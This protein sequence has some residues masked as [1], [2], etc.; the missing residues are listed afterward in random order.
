MTTSATPK[1]LVRSFISS[2]IWAWIVTSSAV[3]GSSAMISLGLH[4]MASAI[5]TRW[6]MP[7]L[8]WCGYW[9]RR[10]PGSEMPTMPS[11][12]TARSLACAGVSLR[13]NSIVSHS[14][15]PIVST[16]LSEVIGSWNTIA[17]CPPRTACSFSSLIAS[18]S[19]PRKRMLPPTTR[20]GGSGIRRSTDS[21]PTDLPQPDSPTMPTVSPS[22]TVYETPSTARTVPAEVSN[23]VRRSFTSSSVAILVCLSLALLEWGVGAEP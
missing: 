21:A 14:C 20:P 12:S 7:P 15:S 11:S 1:R 4:D 23:C 5:I 13:W 18:R 2:R 6:R 10:R 8:R 3:V 9:S 16:G 19:S 22:S 17:I